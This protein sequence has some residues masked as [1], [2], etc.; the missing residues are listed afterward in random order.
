MNTLT[1]GKI[2]END[3]IKSIIIEFLEKNKIIKVLKRA[4]YLEYHPF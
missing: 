4:I 2:V 3:I 1:D